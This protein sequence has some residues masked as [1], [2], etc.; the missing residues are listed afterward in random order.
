[1]DKATCPCCGTPE[2]HSKP[3]AK[4]AAVRECKG[5]GGIYTAA[6]SRLY[7]GESYALVMPHFTNDP[8]ADERARYFDFETLGSNGLGRRHGWFDPETKLITQVG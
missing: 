1:M 5:C 4:Y 7:L 6:G 2:S 3:H 8:A